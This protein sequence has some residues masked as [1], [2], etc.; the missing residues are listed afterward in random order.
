MRHLGRHP[1][2]AAQQSSSQPQLG[3]ATQQLG[4]GAQQLGSATQQLG[5]QQPWP[6]W[7]RRP[8]NK[9]LK[10]PPRRQP[11]S[12]QPMSL[13]QLAPSKP[14]LGSQPHDGSNPQLG[15]QPPPQQPPNSPK[16]SAFWALESTR[17]RLETATPKRHDSSFQ[18][19][20]QNTRGRGKHT[21]YFAATRVPAGL[22]GRRG[23]TAWRMV[24][25]RVAG[26]LGLKR[27]PSHLVHQR[28]RQP[29]LPRF[30]NRHIFLHLPRP[31]AC[32][33]RLY[34]FFGRAVRVVSIPLHCSQEAWVCGP[35]PTTTRIRPAN[36]STVEPQRSPFGLRRGDW[37]LEHGVAFST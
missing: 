18:T 34:R 14:Q 31:P 20:L 10:Q 1:Q 3:S 26:I 29:H 33:R 16:A 12:Q 32:Q 19:L 23:C 11:L 37:K 17:A 2:E 35:L 6:R 24:P 15:S 27:Q 8:E 9:R 13:P 5:S 7:L 21:L 30:A 4:S 28:Y 25:T 22:S 36:A